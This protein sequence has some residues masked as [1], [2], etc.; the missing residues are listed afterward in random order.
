MRKQLPIR[1]AGV[2]KDGIYAAEKAIMLDE[3]EDT[4]FTVPKVITEN[5]YQDITVKVDKDGVLLGLQLERW[6][7]TK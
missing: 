7:P 1:V 3:V 2:T 5:G 4:T 6:D